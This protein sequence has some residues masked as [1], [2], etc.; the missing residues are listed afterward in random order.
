MV[1]LVASF[2]LCNGDNSSSYPVGLW[3]CW[4]NRRH[5]T[6]LCTVPAHSRCSVCGRNRSM[7]TTCSVQHQAAAVGWGLVDSGAEGCPSS[8][9]SHQRPGERRVLPMSQ[10]RCDCGGKL[11]APSRIPRQAVTAGAPA[12]RHVRLIRVLLPLLIPALLRRLRTPCHHC[13]LGVLV[14]VRQGP[15]SPLKL[16][17]VLGEGGGRSEA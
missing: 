2:H 6:A 13:H 4:F 14:Q 3:L 7:A 16:L 17:P 10:Q 8:F 5:R 15:A 9:T 11:S 12:R 1:N